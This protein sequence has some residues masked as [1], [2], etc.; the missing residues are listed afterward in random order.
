M[1]TFAP[2]FFLP[3][4]TFLLLALPFAQAQDQGA[5]YKQLSQKIAE[6]YVSSKKNPGLVVG[7]TQGENSWTFGY[8]ETARGNGQ[9]PQAHTLF[10][11]GSITKVFTT[12]LF[13]DMDVQGLC[14][15]DDPVARF[16]PVTVEVPNYTADRCTTVAEQVMVSDDK[17][18]YFFNTWCYAHPDSPVV[19]ISLCN[20]ATH[21]SGLPRNPDNLKPSSFF[22]RKAFKANPYSRYSLTDLHQG[23]AQQELKQ[24]P[25][26]K[27]AYSNFGMALLGQCLANAGNAPYEQLLRERIL[28]PMGLQNTVFTVSAKQD[29]AQG[30]NAKGKAVQHW[31]F[32]AI[33][34]A[35]ALRSNAVDMLLFVQ[36]NLGIRNPYFHGLLESCHQER[37]KMDNKALATSAV[38]KGWIRTPMQGKEGTIVWH[39][40]GTGGFSSFIGFVEGSQSGVVLLANSANSVTQMGFELLTKVWEEN[41]AKQPE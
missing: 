32:D 30:H 36:S 26:Y 5:R 7:I 15:E 22:K 8:G 10:E 3:L 9:K 11:I 34:P 39:N 16:V 40:G 24:P 4:I 18:V 2:R 35:G 21:S 23:L 20:L 17:A 41:Q 12:L 28:Q 33:S 1:K 6:P 31:D 27:V 25:G 19:Y 14:E 29:F 38:G 37:K 13:A